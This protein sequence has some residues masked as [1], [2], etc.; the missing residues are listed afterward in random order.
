MNG[1]STEPPSP[2]G[3]RSICSGWPV[4]VSNGLAIVGAWNDNDDGSVSGCAYVFEKRAGLWTE[5]AVTG[6]ET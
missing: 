3:K 2:T 6:K 4:G 1:E 5:A